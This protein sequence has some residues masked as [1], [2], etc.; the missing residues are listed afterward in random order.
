MK[1]DKLNSLVELYFI[2]SETID[3][4][5]QFLKWLKPNKT[6]YTRKSV[7]MNIVPK[8]GLGDPHSLTELLFHKAL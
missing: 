3:K 4:D 6:Q 7:S 1:I 2:K 5:K 8:G